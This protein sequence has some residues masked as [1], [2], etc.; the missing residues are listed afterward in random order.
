[1]SGL[2]SPRPDG[3]VPCK[4][5]RRSQAGDALLQ[6]TGAALVKSITRLHTPFTLDLAVWPSALTPDPRLGHLC[7]PPG[8]SPPSSASWWERQRRH[9][10]S[11]S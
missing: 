8:V 4:G 7:P 6:G 1:M 2:R 5:G 9:V 10:L 3:P 11:R